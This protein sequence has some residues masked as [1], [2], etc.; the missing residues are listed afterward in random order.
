MNPS[1]LPPQPLA[2]LVAR[3][4]AR[5]ALPGIEG[6][7]LNNPAP[8]LF[9]EVIVRGAGGCTSQTCAHNSHGYAAPDYRLTPREGLRLV[10]LGDEPALKE[11]TIVYYAVVADDGEARFISVNYPRH[12]HAS[13]REIN[14]SEVPEW[15]LARLANPE[16]TAE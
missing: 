9:D 10:E 8:D 3:A 1:P 15:A 13:A 11:A 2:E 5:M 4:V 12:Y 6:W 16:V 7:G 14:A